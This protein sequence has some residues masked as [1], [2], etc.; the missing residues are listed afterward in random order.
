MYSFDLR[1]TIIP[2]S[3]LQITNLFKEMKPGELMEIVG[4]DASI[5]K[6]LKRILPESACEFSFNEN[7]NGDE[8]VFKV[9]L[10][11]INPH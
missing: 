3:L 5:A 11:K 1:G 4:D 6:D 10:K 9:Q 2:F 8:P 7:C